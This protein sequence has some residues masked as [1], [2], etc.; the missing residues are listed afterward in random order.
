M[1]ERRDREHPA[2]RAALAALRLA[3]TARTVA[4]LQI[5]AAAG[6]PDTAWHGIFARARR[7]PRLAAGAAGIPQVGG[8]HREAQ[9]RPADAQPPRS[10]MQR[11]SI[12]TQRQRPVSAAPGVRRW[13]GIGR[14]AH[15][16][17]T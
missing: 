7:P 2:G 4:R 12:P 8:K 16:R 9:L 17:E 3:I 6:R 13:Q 5:L 14:D 15:E 11:A 1:Y 10:G